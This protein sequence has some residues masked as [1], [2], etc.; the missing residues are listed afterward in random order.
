MNEYKETRRR[1][2]TIRR[3]MIKRC[4]DSS[5][6]DY[7]YYGA[8]GIRVC[9]VWRRSFASFC[10]W[11]LQNGYENNLTIDRIDGSGDYSPENCR[12]VTMSVQNRNKSQ[13]RNIEIDG[14][15]MCL[16]DWCGELGIN[17]ETVAMRIHRGMNEK[18]ALGIYE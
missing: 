16:K 14:R 17:Y 18:E 11:A 8:N 9:S 6:K 7:R 13:T 5:A 1:L 12:W 10:I 4:H 3:N 15:T 2:A